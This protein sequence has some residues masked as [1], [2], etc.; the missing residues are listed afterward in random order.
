LALLRSALAAIGLGGGCVRLR[1]G[2]FIWHC[3]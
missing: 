1:R 2:F 3:F